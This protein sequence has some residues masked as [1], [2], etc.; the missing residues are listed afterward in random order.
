MGNTSSR[1]SI[2]STVPAAGKN[3]P[4]RTSSRAGV[5]RLSLE[6]PLRPDGKRDFAKL[7]GL[8]LQPQA[9]LGKRAYARPVWH[10]SMRAAPGD[11]MLSDDEWA[12]H[13]A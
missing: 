6:P 11:R 8:L 4:T 3:I 2:T 7:T 12:R 9:A 13:R 10:C 1:C 5:T